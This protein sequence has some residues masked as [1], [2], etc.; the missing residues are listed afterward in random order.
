MIPSA[1]IAMPKPILIILHQEHSTPGRVGH[2]LR[3]RGYTL[4]VRRPRL[5]DALPDTMAHHA[6]AVLF[7]GPMS[8]N[9][10]EDF[11]R[12]EIDWLA[13]PLAEE[14]PFLGICLGAQLLA[15]QL[16]SSVYCHAQGE[17]EVGYYPIRPTVAG[18][19]MCGFWPDHVYQWHREGFD[20]P[21]GADLLAE[22]DVFPVQAFRYGPAAYAI[23][24]HPE[25][26]HAMM[27]RWTTRGHARLSLPGAKPRLAHFED[28]AV[29]DYAIRAWLTSFLDRWAGREPPA[30]AAE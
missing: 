22:G 13:V 11:I 24:F 9:D 6:G 17:V 30:A 5:G 10:E 3:S 16:G 28:R 27:C 14:K 15:R 18:R 12:R 23:Q 25:V 4:D 1:N 29:H 19:A 7:G 2:A 8:A 26:T 20:L 21:R